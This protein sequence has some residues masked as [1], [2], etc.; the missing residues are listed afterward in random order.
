MQ[1][2]ETAVFVLKVIMPSDSH[3]SLEGTNKLYIHQSST[4]EAILLTYRLD[5]RLTKELTDWLDTKQI[6]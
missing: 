6:H 2:C 3:T 4:R 1:C 5:N